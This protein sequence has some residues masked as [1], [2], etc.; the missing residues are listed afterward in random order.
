MTKE[1]P[2]HSFRLVSAVGTKEPLFS[3]CSSKQGF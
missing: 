2:S 3:F 1:A